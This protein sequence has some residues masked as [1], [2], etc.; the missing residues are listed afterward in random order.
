MIIWVAGTG[1]IRKLYALLI[2]L[3]TILAS[4]VLAQL[5]LPVERFTL[6]LVKRLGSPKPKTV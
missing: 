5:L 3:A 4:L 6:A 2:A 1:T